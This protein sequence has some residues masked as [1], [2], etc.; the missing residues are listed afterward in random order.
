[1]CMK[2]TSFIQRAMETF[3]DFGNWK[4]SEAIFHDQYYRLSNSHARHSIKTSQ[5]GIVMEARITQ[6]SVRCFNAK[7]RDKVKKLGNCIKIL[8]AFFFRTEFL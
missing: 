2:I 4:L 5:Q 3:L 6:T 7:V 1:M 8:E